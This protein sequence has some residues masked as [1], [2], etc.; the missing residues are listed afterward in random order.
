MVDDGIAVY[1]QSYVVMFNG[2]GLN[3][4]HKNRQHRSAHE[5]S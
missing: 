1:V 5:V 4:L 3:G 2:A